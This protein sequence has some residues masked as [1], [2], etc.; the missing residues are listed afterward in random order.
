M[1]VYINILL[2]Q[3]ASYSCL[4]LEVGSWVLGDF[5]CVFTPDSKLQTPNQIYLTLTS[6]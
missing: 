6:P 4:L 3:V 5:I 2:T 1:D